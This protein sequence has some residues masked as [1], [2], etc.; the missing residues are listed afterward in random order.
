MGSYGI[1]IPQGLFYIDNEQ[2]TPETNVNENNDKPNYS[3]S[4]KS[5]GMTEEEYK[6]A[7]EEAFENQGHDNYGGG[8]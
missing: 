2:K 3:E 8:L 7:L 6:R 5:W 4:A 1:L